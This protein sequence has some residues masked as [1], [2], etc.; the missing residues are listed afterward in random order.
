MAC[1]SFYK[2]LAKSHTCGDFG[3]MNL[4][5]VLPIKSLALNFVIQERFIK[6]SKITYDNSTVVTFT[7][8]FVLIITLGTLY[9]GKLLFD[10]LFNVNL[11]FFPKI[12]RNNISIRTSIRLEK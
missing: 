1:D 6:M 8:V 4:S 11:H 7:I 9:M 5:A 3:S 12:I 2:Y 10:D